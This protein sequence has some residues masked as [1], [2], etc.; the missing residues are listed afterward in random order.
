MIVNPNVELLF[1]DF[2][3]QYM[4]TVKNLLDA[5]KRLPGETIHLVHSIS[6][7]ERVLRERDSI[8]MIAFHTK[9]G[10]NVIRKALTKLRRV[11]LAEIMVISLFEDEDDI[12]EIYCYG[13]NILVPPIYKPE[14]A[15]AY[16][17]SFFSRHRLI[18]SICCMKEAAHIKDDVKMQCGDII[19]DPARH[20]VQRNA[21]IITLTQR[22]FDLL[23]FFACNEGIVFTQEQLFQ[24]VWNSE[25]PFNTSI[26]NR[27]Y[28]LR[29]KIEPD[30]RNP[31]YIQTVYGVGY[32]FVAN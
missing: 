28:R 4:K 23:Y 3:P 20:L 14:M 6:D 16:F 9:S 27:I 13:M 7:G 17:E 10:K 5:G 29:K 31:T 19:I 12:S 25:Y 24:Y 18:P 21:V 15:V 22:E 8:E 11:S 32:K 1:I 30:L 2:D 26:C